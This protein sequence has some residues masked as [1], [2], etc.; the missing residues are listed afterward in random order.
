MSR[1]TALLK[2]TE[3]S[4]KA[5]AGK[6]SCSRFPA[7]LY[8]PPLFLCNSVWLG[9]VLCWRMGSRVYQSIA[10]FCC[11]LVPLWKAVELGRSTGEADSWQKAGRM[12]KTELWL[13]GNVIGLYP[14]LAAQL[15]IKG[16]VSVTL[17][18]HF[19]QLKG[20]KDCCWLLQRQPA[21][22]IW[23]RICSRKSWWR[24]W[25]L[26]NPGTM[27]GCCLLQLQCLFLC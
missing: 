16:Y 14:I 10:F 19:L 8:P 15:E 26:L 18:S 25:L 1:Q 6:C 17:T 23:Y 9:N 13:A 2:F 11:F 27:S 20:K 12:R 22:E 21:Y 5:E 3:L 7:V 24:W 4:G